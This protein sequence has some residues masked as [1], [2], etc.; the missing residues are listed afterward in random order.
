MYYYVLLLVFFFVVVVV[1]AVVDEWSLENL[2]GCRITAASLTVVFSGRW[3]VVHQSLPGDDK[4][5]SYASPGL[6]GK[7]AWLQKLEHFESLV[8]HGKGCFNNLWRVAGTKEHLHKYPNHP[9]PSAED[10]KFWPK[11][12]MHHVIGV[13]GISLLSIAS[14]F[15]TK[16]DPVDGTDYRKL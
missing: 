13:I 16:L 4:G 7:W 14:W 9:F 15:D 12:H 5:W 2:R 11:E 3:R 1:V 10:P 8:F 6:G